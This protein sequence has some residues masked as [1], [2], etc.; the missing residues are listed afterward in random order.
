MTI[1]AKPRVRTAVD[2]AT[3]NADI[4][5]RYPALPPGRRRRSPSTP[6]THCTG[7]W[8]SVYFGNSTL[9]IGRYSAVTVRSII[10]SAQYPQVPDASAAPR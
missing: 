9:S 7:C 8:W 1:D 4:G 6:V 5:R 10:P 3:G 2:H